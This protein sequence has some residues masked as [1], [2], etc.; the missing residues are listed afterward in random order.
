M[1]KGN[2]CYLSINYGK[3]ADESLDQRNWSCLLMI[4]SEKIQVKSW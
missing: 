2:V 3:G 4:K 1:I